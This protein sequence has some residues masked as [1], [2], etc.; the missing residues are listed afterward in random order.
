VMDLPGE[1]K[2][3]R[4]EFLDALTQLDRQT[5]QQRIDDLQQRLVEKGLA[6]AEKA[7]LRAL[8]TQRNEER[9]RTS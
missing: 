2:A 1:T 7:E 9:Q 4:M 3:L 6:N 8:L 5:T